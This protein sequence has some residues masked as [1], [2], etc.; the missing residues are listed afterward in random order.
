MYSIESTKKREKFVSSTY[1]WIS[2]F[3]VETFIYHGFV[4]NHTILAKHTRIV[5]STRQLTI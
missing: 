3:F 2:I 5:S 1:I 4:S